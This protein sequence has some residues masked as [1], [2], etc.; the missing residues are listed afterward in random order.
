VNGVITILAA[1]VLPLGFSKVR[2][3]NLSLFR[4][5]QQLSLDKELGD[6]NQRSCTWLLCRGAVSQLGMLTAWQYFPQQLG[7][8]DA[9]QTFF[10]FPCLQMGAPPGGF[11]VQDQAENLPVRA[12]DAE[13]S[14]HYMSGSSRL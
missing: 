8:M 10:V 12:G 13:A 6:E 14:A 7:L 5:K 2:R 4:K 11:L 3:C 9:E 1:A